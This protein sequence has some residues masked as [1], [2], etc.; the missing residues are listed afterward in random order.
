[1]FDEV[2][3][4]LLGPV[5][6]VE[7]AHERRVLLEQLA[8]RPGDLVGARSLFRLPSRER[9][10]AAAAGSD[11]SASSCFTASTTGQ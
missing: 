8:E 2:E 7:G 3:E 4:R 11:G 1:M 5:D 10:E 6:V 9:S